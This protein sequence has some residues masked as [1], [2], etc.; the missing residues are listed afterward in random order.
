MIDRISWSI[1][2]KLPSLLRGVRGG[3]G[4]ISGKF[5]FRLSCTQEN[6]LT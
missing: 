5:D 6:D 3:C 4:M 1:V 2:L